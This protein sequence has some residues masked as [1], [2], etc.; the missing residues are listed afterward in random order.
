M[1]H[2][3]VLLQSCIWW[4]PC[5]DLLFYHKQ[6]IPLM[7]FASVLKE[8]IAKQSLCRQFEF[9]WGLSDQK[10]INKSVLLHSVPLFFPLSCSTLSKESSWDSSLGDILLHSI[11]VTDIQKP[12]TLRNR[13][14]WQI[15]VP[16]I[17][18]LPS[19]LI[20]L[21]PVTLVITTEWLPTLH[22]DCCC[23]RRR[24]L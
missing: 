9:I 4:I 19:R 21:L 20:T 7:C 1:E 12:H 2:T 23:D 13:Q 16:Q 14:K 8:M 11:C 15:F 24:R 22:N 10:R 6:S 5:I 17:P 3:G 18:A